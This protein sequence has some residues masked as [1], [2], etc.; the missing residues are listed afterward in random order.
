MRTGESEAKSGIVTRLDNVGCWRRTRAQ[1]GALLTV[2]F[3]TFL[4]T[5]QNALYLSRCFYFRF[6][7]CDSNCN[8]IHQVHFLSPAQHHDV[9]SNHSLPPPHLELLPL[10]APALSSSVPESLAVFPTPSTF[11]LVATSP[12][13]ASA[14]TTQRNHTT[15]SHTTT[16]LRLGLQHTLSTPPSFIHPPPRASFLCAFLHL[17]LLTLP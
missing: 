3:Y 10:Q 12:P 16:R 9:Y 11:A 1:I 8:Q 7:P 14:Q 15:K 6:A 2:R 17:G 5:T 13:S 4:R